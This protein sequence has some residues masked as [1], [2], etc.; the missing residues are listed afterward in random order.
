MKCTTDFVLA[1]NMIFDDNPYLKPH[2][3]ATRQ[4]LHIASMEAQLSDFL[5]QYKDDQM[6]AEEERE[7][8]AAD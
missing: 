1:S 2:P 5:K 7:L 6:K 8:M 4:K 3:A